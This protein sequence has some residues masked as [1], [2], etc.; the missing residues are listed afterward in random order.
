MQLLL[1]KDK[2]ITAAQTSVSGLS[3]KNRTVNVIFAIIYVQI[4]QTDTAS[5]STATA[6]T[7][8]PVS[9]PPAVPAKRKR[10]DKFSLPPVP[11]TRTG[12]RSQDKPR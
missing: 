10:V 8:H 7:S 11:G 4:L 6:S 9:D 12:L 1:Y 2:N 3:Y 5:E